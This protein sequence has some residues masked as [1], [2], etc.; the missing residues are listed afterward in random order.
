MS[1]QVCRWAA[2]V[3]ALGTACVAGAQD[4]FRQWIRD[5]VGKQQFSVRYEPLSYFNADVGGQDTQLHAVSHDLRAT[6]PLAQDEVNEWA[7]GL[8]FGVRDFDTDARI[9][10][11]RFKFLG[12]RAA[13][14]LGEPFPG[15]IYDIRLTPTYRRKLDNGWVAG[16]SL[17][18]GSI[19]DRPFAS[20][21]EILV[22][23]NA[24]VR[25]PSGEHNAWL[26]M[27]NYANDRS[28]AHN[29]PIPGVAYAFAFGPQL[30]GMVGVPFSN[31]HWEPVENLELDASYGLMR[32][33][34]AEVGYRVAPPVKLY[35][36]YAWTNERY[37]HADRRDA[38]DRLFYYEQR[39]MGGARWELNEAARVDLGAGYAFDRF[40]FS[41]EDWDDRRDARLDVA[42][43]PI[44]RLQL[45]LRF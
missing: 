38:D 13:A 8:R 19:S 5:D 39:V 10:D 15:E 34:R 42:D 44:L 7:L 24:F 40:Y 6:V 22:R 12:A 16:G 11:Q 36:Q 4:Q 9:P 32:R 29:I 28:F 31:L 33:V 17:T 21:D 20:G 1:L 2:V 35:A 3:A 14:A 18:L 45:A 37:F 23:G 41:G 25:I 27:L 30:R 26:L 43:G